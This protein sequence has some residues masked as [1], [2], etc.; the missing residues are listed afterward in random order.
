MILAEARVPYYD[1]PRRVEADRAA[2]KAIVRDVARSG[3]FILKRRVASL[4]DELAAFTGARHAIG[5]AS[6][7]AAIHLGLAALRAGPGDEVITPAFSF[8]SSATPIAHLG[9]TPV[10]VDVEQDTALVDPERVGAAVTDR[11][12]GLVAVHLFSAMADMPSLSELARDRGLWVLEDSAIALGMSWDGRAAGRWGDLGLFS[13]HPYKP[14][15]GISDGAALVTDD[16]ELA[17]RCRMLRNH[18]QDGVH[19]FLHHAIGFNARMDEVNAAFL[20]RRLE[21]YRAG[22]ARRAEIAGR[23]DAA[24][25]HLA[26]ALRTPPAVAHERIHYTYVVRAQERDELERH[27]AARGVETVVY[28]PLPLHLQPVFAHLGHRPGDFPNAERA[29]RECLA[30][31]LY[32]EMPDDHVEEAIAA[33]LAFFDG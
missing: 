16:D 3:E 23:Y 9:A 7:T 5:T 25:A 32:P 11:T 24:L 29:S 30:L 2:L 27:L 4:E 12:A 1:L 15:G 18:G 19:R 21:R 17:R 26:P 20:A 28:Y 14:L 33:V 31:P 8:H 13:F 6:G 10:L 22:L